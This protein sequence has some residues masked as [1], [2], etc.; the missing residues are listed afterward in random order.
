LLARSAVPTLS[1]AVVILASCGAPQVQP[2]TSG[3]VAQAPNS[4]SWRAPE[5]HRDSLLY[6]SDVR[7]NTVFVYSYPEGRL[8]DRL[9][10]FQRPR[11]ECAD[12]SGDVWIADSGGYQMVEYAHGGTQ[13]IAALS[14]PNEPRGCSIDPTTGNLAVTGAADRGGVFVYHF[15]KHGQWRDPRQYGGSA[16]R[17][18]YFA[19][20]DASGNLFVDGFDKLAGGVFRFA[21]LPRDGNALVNV[22]LNQQINAP[23]Q[24]Q[25]DGQHIAIGDAGTT[26]STIFQFS[27]TG[28]HASK[29]GTTTLGGSRSVRQFWIG[30]GTVVGPDFNRDVALWNYPS[31]GSP[32]KKLALFGYGA[33]ISLAP[34]VRSVRP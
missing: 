21:E 32:I 20:Y 4:R 7:T 34:H 2:A 5:A 23:G 14:T 22:S 15:S 29:V 13:P 25:W 31:G 3:A 28:N 26:P 9:T 11:S 24:V 19:G 18:A 6:L 1:I 27:V 17:S 30:S 10:G 8:V 33:A 16:I 12:A